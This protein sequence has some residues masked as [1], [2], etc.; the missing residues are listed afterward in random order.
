MRSR[1]AVRRGL[2]RRGAKSRACRLVR[3]WPIATAPDCQPS[4]RRPS[5][6]SG[7]TSFP[8]QQ[9]TAMP[10]ELTARYRD[11]AGTLHQMRLERAPNGCWRV[12]DVGPAGAHLVE[13]LT[14]C[15]DHRPQ[16]EALARDYAQQ[17]EI[18]AHGRPDDDQEV[19]WA[20]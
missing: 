2:H 15:D 6:R 14:G 12:L 19:V 1:R 4:T 16:A 5:R 7:P 17:A 13:E 10:Y 3:A 9:E 8:R 18:A 11:A 20:A